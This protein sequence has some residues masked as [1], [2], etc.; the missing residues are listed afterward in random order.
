VKLLQGHYY[1]PIEGEVI[2]ELLHIDLVTQEAQ[3]C[4]KDR[5]FIIPLER[6]Q[7]YF[8]EYVGA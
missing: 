7:E 4:Y 3:W 2:G 5:V 8:E 1:K 6:F